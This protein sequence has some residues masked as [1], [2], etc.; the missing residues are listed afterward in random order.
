MEVY[1]ESWVL[2]YVLTMIL[3]G[4]GGMAI[5]SAPLVIVAII[6]DISLLAFLII[7]RG[8]D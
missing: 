3:C 2:L 1:K 6:M 5:R 4:F 7:R 8:M